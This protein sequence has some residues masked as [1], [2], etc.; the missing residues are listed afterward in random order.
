[1][2]AEEIMSQSDIDALIARMQAGGDAAPATDDDGSSD[3]DASA[4]EVD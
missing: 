3:G 1:M 4:S 2:A